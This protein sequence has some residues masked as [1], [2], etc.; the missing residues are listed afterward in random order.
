MKRIF[1]KKQKCFLM[2]EVDLNLGLPNPSPPS[3]LLQSCFLSHWISVHIDHSLNTIH[4]ILPIMSQLLS[5]H[6]EGSNLSFWIIS[7]IV[8]CRVYYN[9][10]I[11]FQKWVFNFCSVCSLFQKDFLAGGMAN[12]SYFCLFYHFNYVIIMFFLWS[13]NVF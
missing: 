10:N 5:F 4:L 3:N 8:N 1:L 9:V 12:K 7:A 6:K 13:G 11:P 2:T